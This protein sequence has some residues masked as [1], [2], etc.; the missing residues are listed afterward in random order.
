MIISH[1]KCSHKCLIAM[2]CESK[3]ETFRCT[4]IPY[5]SHLQLIKGENLESG[6]SFSELL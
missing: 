6:I 3:L 2:N 5:I 4:M 1:A